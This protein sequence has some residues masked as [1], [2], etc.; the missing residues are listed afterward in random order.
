MNDIPGTGLPSWR[1]SGDEGGREIHVPGI[2]L[3]LWRWSGVGGSGGEIHVP[4][5]ALPSWRWSEGGVGSGGEI[6]VPGI[7]L[8]SWRW[9][10]VGGSGG[11]IHVPGIALP[12]WRWSEGGVRGKEIHRSA[13]GEGGLGVGRFTYLVQRSHCGAGRRNH[14]V[15]EEEERILGAQVDPL[16]DEE[17]ELSDRQV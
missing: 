13:G 1:W 11:E 4:G 8:L 2:A 12:S 14:V 5:I 17:V 16:P 3:P 6:H 15:D 9:A 10:G 7:A